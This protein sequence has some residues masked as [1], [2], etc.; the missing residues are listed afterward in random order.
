MI[1]EELQQH[2]TSKCWWSLIKSLTGSSFHSH[3]ATPPASQLA[4]YFS[5]KLSH[6]AD[7]LPIPSLTD[8]HISLFSEFQ[9]KISHVRRVLASLN[10]TK[11]MGDDNVS[12]R[13]LKSCASA[14]GGPL[15]ALFR[16]MHHSLTHG[17]LVELHQFIRRVQALIPLITDL[18]LF[19]PLFLVFLNYC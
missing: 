18:L 14:L 7:L 8:S 10:T 17:K 1:Q 6:P 15:T 2:S 4:G 16:T 12:P 3:P 9:I 11:S 19:Y 5:S 13:V